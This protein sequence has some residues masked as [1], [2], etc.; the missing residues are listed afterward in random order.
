MKTIKDVLDETGILIDYLDENVY[1]F[2]NVANGN[3]NNTINRTISREYFYD[4]K[5]RENYKEHIEKRLSDGWIVI[6]REVIEKHRKCVIDYFYKNGMLLITIL[7]TK[8]KPRFYFL[9]NYPTKY[10]KEIQGIEIEYNNYK[11]IKDKLNKNVIKKYTNKR[12]FENMI[13]RLVLQGI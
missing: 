5:L 1:P 4:D 3:S 13:N 2:F 9:N 11:I 12:E 10:A 6:S 7:D 8:K